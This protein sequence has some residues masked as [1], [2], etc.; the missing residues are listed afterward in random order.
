MLAELGHWARGHSAASAPH[1]NTH[2]R[3]PLPYFPHG[4]LATRTEGQEEARGGARVVSSGEHRPAGVLTCLPQGQEEGAD[5]LRNKT[6]ACLVGGP[7]L[8]WPV[9]GEEVTPS[10]AVQAKH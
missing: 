1:G 2:L 7:P 6:L 9:W 3:P 10:L 4:A 5:T 8:A